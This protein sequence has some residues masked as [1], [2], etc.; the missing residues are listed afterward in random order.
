MWTCKNLNRTSRAIFSKGSN[1]EIF[2]LIKKFSK[3]N[4]KENEEA[5]LR[6]NIHN[7]CIREG[8]AHTLHNISHKRIRK[9]NPVMKTNRQKISEDTP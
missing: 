3:D 6:Y 4:T 2:S 7:L 8:L 5:L 1:E 9:Y